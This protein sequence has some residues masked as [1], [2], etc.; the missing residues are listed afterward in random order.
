VAWKK[1]DLVR[2]KSS[3][4]SGPDMTVLDVSNAGVRC[5][6]TDNS[7]RPHDKVF[8]DEALVEGASSY[9]TIN[10]DLGAKRQEGGQGQE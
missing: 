6:W 2:L 3:K 1:S 7:G 5:C 9:L 10:I 8:P 4:V